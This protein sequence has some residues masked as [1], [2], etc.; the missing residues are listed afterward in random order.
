M[1]W[2]GG[3]KTRAI[4][5]EAG[6]VRERAEVNGDVGNVN[7]RRQVCCLGYRL[8]SF[9]AIL[10]RLLAPGSQGWHGESRPDWLRAS[11]GVALATV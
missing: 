4:P 10:L 5:G 11:R 8:R 2:V 9:E 7:S 1:V 6:L 3:R